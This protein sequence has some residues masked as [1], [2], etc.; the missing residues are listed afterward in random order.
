MKLKLIKS[1]WGM[2]G[3]LEDQIARIAEAG[4]HGVES[5]I[6]E[7]ERGQLLKK[8]LK[9]HKLQ[10]IVQVF[11]VGNDVNEHVDTFS[12]VVEKAK[13]FEP[14]LINSQS[15]R[16]YW[17]FAQ[18]TAFFHDALEIERKSGVLICH[19][20]HRSRAMFSAWSTSALLNEFPELKITA[21][22]SHFCCVSETLLQDQAASVAFCG[23]RAR[24]LHGRIGHIEGP[25]VNDPR[26][27]EW[28]ENLSAHEAWWREIVA[29]RKNAGAVEFTF[30]PEFGPLPYMPSLPYT[31]QPLVDL[32]D[33][34]LWMA[35][36][37]EG[38]YA[39]WNR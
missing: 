9:E 20:T 25:Q 19:E 36:R 34:C 24:H 37:F 38:K 27:P 23:S 11:S 3:R 26:A 22:F 29:A 39:E 16:D 10:H 35:K 18:Q 13:F 5:V 7:G 1:L 30:T 32:W 33:V 21:D 6:L 31:Q 8:L 12:E 28:A 4:Y 15:A 17:T 2:T 14:L